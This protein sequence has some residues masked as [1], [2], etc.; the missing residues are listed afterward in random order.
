[1]HSQAGQRVTGQT[2]GHVAIL[3]DL[4]T[5]LQQGTMPHSALASSGMLFSSDAQ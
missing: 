5:I 4:T 1:M 2:E 3:A